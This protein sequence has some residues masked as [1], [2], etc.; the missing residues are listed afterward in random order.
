M[1]TGYIDGE[2]LHETGT[3]PPAV[4]ERWLLLWDGDC[5]FCRRWV[6]RA[7]RRDRAGLLLAL[8][9]Q[10]A[11]R[12]L[13]AAVRE[14]SPHQAHLRSPDGRYW[15]GGAAVIRLCGLLGHPRLERVLCLPG[16]RHAVA[17]GYLLVSRHRGWL[18]RWI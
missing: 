15:G 5:G 14:R 6:Q 13:P 3:A 16:L 11:L 17:L 9:Y 12:W 18:A 8:P 1:N 4:Q 10:E 7:L 2:R